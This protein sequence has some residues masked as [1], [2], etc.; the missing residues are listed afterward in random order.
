MIRRMA[1]LLC[2][3]FVVMAAANPAPRDQIATGTVRVYL[4][5]ADLSQRLTRQPDLYFSSERDGAAPVIYVDDG[6]TY[7][8]IDGFGGAMTDTS[9]WLLG[10]QL[11]PTVRDTVMHNLFDPMQGIGLS[12]MRLPMGASDFVKDS[13][14]YSYDDLPAGSTDPAL[15]LFSIDHDL[16][17]TIP[18][19][20]EAL[21]I[22]PQLKLMANPWTP[23]AWMKTPDGDAGAFTGQLSPSFYPTLARYF[24]KFIQA[25][26]AQAIPIYAISPQ[27]EPGQSSFNGE[28]M[29][30]PA[31]DEAT[32]IARYLG[33]ALSASNLSPHILAYDSHWN[34]TAT[35]PDYPFV[36][37]GDPAAYKYLA[38]TAWHCYAG[39]PEAMTRMHNAYPQ[40]DNYE[41]ECMTGIS[42][43]DPA[44]L[45]IAS[46]RNWAQGVLLWNLALD[47]KGGPTYLGAG[48]GSICDAPLTVDESTGAVTYN[49]DFYQLGQASAFVHPGAYRI[50]T[51]S[52]VARYGNGNPCG[53]G[54]N[55]YGTGRVDNVAFKNPD[56][57]KV[58]L[59]Y[60]G[61]LHDQTFEVLWRGQGFS[62][63]LPS[64][65]TVTFIWSG[66]A[67][68]SLSPGLPRLQSLGVQH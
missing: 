59:A 14:V 9:A 19:L 5:T 10:T 26:A 43:G 41:T 20:Q 62:Y 52:F 31:Q 38:G 34:P 17:Y 44:E 16:S 68:R 53:K 36:V 27:N 37:M 7:Q 11:A 60:N 21:Q 46:T 23:P 22:N 57:S 3:L 33:P 1:P 39:S 55:S 4:T 65:A 58:L 30:F 15:S 50:D 51:N 61:A 35:T 48:C 67:G 45:I 2:G 12:F 6:K 32:F 56:G 66:V 18:L 64:C 8:R 63:T 40:K 28:A 49:R 47:P 29:V 13:V 42:H 54:G 25:Y 24:V